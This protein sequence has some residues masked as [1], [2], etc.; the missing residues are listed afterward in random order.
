ML[1]H[2]PGS[3]CPGLLVVWGRR[4]VDESLGYLRSSLSVHQAAEARPNGVGACFSHKARRLETIIQGWC[5]GSRTP[6]LFP[7]ALAPLA[8]TFILSASPG[9]L[10]LPSLN[11]LL[12][13]QKRRWNPQKAQ[14]GTSIWRALI[15]QT[16]THQLLHLFDQNCVTW[17]R[18]WQRGLEMKLI[19]YCVAVFLAKHIATPK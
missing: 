6:L 5:S 18:L 9:Y 17:P 19:F 15:S 16:P 13:F 1:A 4:H 8:R 14:E 12:T 10:R 2:Q 11:L 3:H 7:S